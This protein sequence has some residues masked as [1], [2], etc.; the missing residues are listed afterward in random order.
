[1]VLSNIGA[2]HEWMQML[3]SARRHGWIDDSLVWRDNEPL[4]WIKALLEHN[5]DVRPTSKGLITT[6][7]DSLYS[8]N[9]AC[10]DC[11]EDFMDP[12]FRDND[13]HRSEGDSRDRIESE[14]FTMFGTMAEPP[15]QMDNRK[16]QTVAKRLEQTLEHYAASEE[17]KPFP[18]PSSFTG[19]LDEEAFKGQVSSTAKTT[20]ANTKRG[21]CR[22]R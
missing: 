5:P 11:A 22:C 9:F 12:R 7:A 18:M 14:A 17:P 15:E 2:V 8:R 20:G 10:P 6:I 16:T 13:G 3:T 1:M 4:T 21:P 19:W